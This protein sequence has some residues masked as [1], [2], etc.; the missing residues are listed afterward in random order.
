VSAHVPL[1]YII[2]SGVRR[3]MVSRLEFGE[4]RFGV[5]LVAL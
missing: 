2:P 1:Q 5:I 4:V 3:I